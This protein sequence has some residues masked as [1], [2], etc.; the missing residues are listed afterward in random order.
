[1]VGISPSEAKRFYDGFGARQDAQGWYEHPAIRDLLDHAALADARSLLEVGCG[2]GRVAAEIL[3]RDETANDLRYL[4]L[5]ISETMIGLA[6]ER[7]VRFGPR[8][9]VFRVDVAATDGLPVADGGVDRV[10]ATYVLELMRP[11]DRDRLVDAAAKALAPGG[12]LCVVNLT[13]GERG[14][15]RLVS[16]AWRRLVDLSPARL[17]GCRPLRLAEALPRDRWEVVYRRVVAAFAVSSEV[18]VARPR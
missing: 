16:G 15:A 3:T 9:Q 11:D 6:R 5:D 4:G 10:L 17:G 1:M 8:A 18:L 13:E 2:T 12:L 7:L 14:V